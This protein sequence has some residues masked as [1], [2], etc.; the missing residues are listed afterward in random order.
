VI[1]AWTFN[2]QSG[3]TQWGNA[4]QIPIGSKQKRATALLG[5]ALKF[6]GAN[7]P[8]CLNCHGSDTEIGDAGSGG[9]D[10]TWNVNDIAGILINDVPNG[11]A[12][13]ILIKACATHVTN[14][15]ARLAVS[16]QNGRG[17]NGVWIY[18]YNLALSATQSFP[19]PTKLSSQVD[20]QGTQVAF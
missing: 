12:G 15:S 4:L 14:F 13:P 6:L 5:E 18:G 1:V 2:P 3:A 17:L 7:E 8:L 11:Y 16:L 20:L 9:N 19:D 10:W